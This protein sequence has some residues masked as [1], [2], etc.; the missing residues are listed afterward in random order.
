MKIERIVPA[1]A[2]RKPRDVAIGELRLE[3]KE[4]RRQ[5]RALKAAVKAEQ[6][7]ATGMLR[8]MQHMSRIMTEMTVRE[9]CRCTPSR[10]EMLR[11]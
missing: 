4:A 3:L 5:I 11:R 9:A 7:H 8:S 6:A 1:R 2:V 10:A